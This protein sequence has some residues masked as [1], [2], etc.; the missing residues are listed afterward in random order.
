M[1]DKKE[2]KLTKREQRRKEIFIE[3][4]CSMEEEG[5]K[6]E[7]LFFSILQANFV[8]LLITL[9]INFLFLAVHY[10]FNDFVPNG[11]Y[12]PYIGLIFIALMLL[13]IVVHELIHG[14]TWGHFAAEG[15]KSI[16]FGVIWQAL[17]PYCTCSSPL[18][19][20]EYIKGALMPTIVLGFIPGIIAAITG[21]VPLLILSQLMILA[22][23]GDVLIVARLLL[24]RPKKAKVVYLDHPTECGLVAFVKKN[25]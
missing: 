12:S 14:I 19:K 10:L 9:P 8:G 18:T 13:L 7:N 4:C 3:K 21:W 2:R 17:T 6:T 20:G 1:S 16:E 15:R 23:A 11:S 25:D 5:Y 22:G 24:H